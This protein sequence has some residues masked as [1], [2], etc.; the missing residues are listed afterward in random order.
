LHAGMHTSRNLI[1]PFSPQQ[2][3]SPSSPRQMSSPQHIG[4]PSSFGQGYTPQS[5]SSTGGPNTPPT[6]PPRKE[7]LNYSAPW[8]VY[9]LD[10]SNQPTEREALRLAVGSFIEDGSNKVSHDAEFNALLRTI[11]CDESCRS[12]LECILTPR[13]SPYLLHNDSRFKSSPFLSLPE[14]RAKI[15]THTPCQTGSPSRRPT[16][17]STQ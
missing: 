10:W 11:T 3:H 1:V 13:L 16:T 9:G 12:S 14:S 17:N 4:A 6:R 15:T 7:I 8:P 2:L 5:S